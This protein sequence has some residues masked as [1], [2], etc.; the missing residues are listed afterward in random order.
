MPKEYSP[1]QGQSLAMIFLSTNHVTRK[2]QTPGSHE[3]DKGETV[4]KSRASWERVTLPIQV[5]PYSLSLAFFI[6][7]MGI[8][9]LRPKSCHGDQIR[10]Q[11]APW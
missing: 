1:Q 5:F 3:H 6:H 2:A 7:K 9:M 10:T 11:H 8:W 4:S